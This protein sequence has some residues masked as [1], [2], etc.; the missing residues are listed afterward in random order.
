M[1]VLVLGS[2]QGGTGVDIEYVVKVAED[3]AKAEVE[4]ATPGIIDAAVAQSL[5]QNRTFSAWD[6]SALEA[7][8]AYFVEASETGGALELPEGGV[9][10][11]VSG[12]INQ[13]VSLGAL[14]LASNGVYIA[15]KL[16]DDWQIY[17]LPDTSFIDALRQEFNEAFA[18]QKLGDLADVD[19][20]GAQAGD[21]V[22][23]DGQSWKPVAAS[24]AGDSAGETTSETI[25][26]D[27]MRAAQGLEPRRTAR[28]YSRIPRGYQQRNNP[29]FVT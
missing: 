29:Y 3:A 26:Y 24:S 28:T 2:Q 14:E 4:A 5:D 15:S 27:E 7:N 12:Q 11:V 18:A 20:S 21:V 22:S 8:R 9:V 1:K 13:S 16:L 19:L 25:S 17:R 6:G 10:M 23:F